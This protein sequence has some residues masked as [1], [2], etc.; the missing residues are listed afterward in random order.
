MNDTIIVRKDCP[1]KCIGENTAG[2][3]WWCQNCGAIID[4]DGT[5][6]EE[7]LYIDHET[8]LCPDQGYKE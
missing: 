8:R 3:V 7:P 2:C 6:L 4:D 1:W 5:G